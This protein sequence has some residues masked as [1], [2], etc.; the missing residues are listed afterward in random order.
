MQIKA[1]E[2]VKAKGSSVSKEIKPD[3]VKIEKL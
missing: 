1:S 2:K 3:K